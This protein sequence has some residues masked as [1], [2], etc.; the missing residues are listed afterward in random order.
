[1]YKILI[2]KQAKGGSTEQQERAVELASNDLENQLNDKSIGV[3]NIFGI[4]VHDMNPLTTE[5][6]A[7]VEVSDPVIKKKG[8]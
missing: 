5:V 1:M 7:L 3:K 8:E 2:G 6:I 4:V